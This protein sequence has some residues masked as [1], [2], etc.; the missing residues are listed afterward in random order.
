MNRLSRAVRLPAPEWVE[1]TLSKGGAVAS[2]FTNAVALA[3]DG[4][5][6]PGIKPSHQHGLD[7][8]LGVAL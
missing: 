6:A 8:D 3:A 1:E 7:F 5:M 4:A 2:T